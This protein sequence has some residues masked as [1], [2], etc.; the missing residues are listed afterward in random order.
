MMDEIQKKI[1]DLKVLIVVPTYNNETTIKQVVE[2]VRAYSSNVLVVNDGSTDSTSSI[3]GDLGVENISYSPN[4]GKGYAIRQS[5]KWAKERG[6]DYVLTIDSD[7]QHYASDIPQFIEAIESNPDSLIVGARNLTADNMPSK[8][9]FANKFS[10]F[11][12]HVETGTKLEDTQSGFRLYPIRKIGKTKYCTSRYEF[13]VEVIVRAAWSGV[14]VFNIPIKVYYPPVEERVSHFRPLKDFT[15]IS[16]LNTCLFIIALL[17]YY[18]FAA[19]R[20]LTKKNIKLFIERNI[21]KNE[22][23]NFKIAAAMSLGVIFGIV[24]IWGYQMIAVAAVAHL[25]RLN[26]VIA[27]VFSNI[28]IPPMI[29]FI[30]YGSLLSG[31]IVLRRDSVVDFSAVTFET[32]SQDMI[33]YILGACVLALIAGVAIFVVAYAMLSIFRNKRNG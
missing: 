3:I 33:Q 9:T 29:P 14:K 23:S 4:R 30:L 10:N 24:P 21:T 20:L 6:Y 12:F 17:Y 19:L 18:P 22:E 26:K 8:N 32:V 15:R 7:G 1:E 31:S 27:L 5:F 25:L 2:D 11:W 16:I 13:E 28:S